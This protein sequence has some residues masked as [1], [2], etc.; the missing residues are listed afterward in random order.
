M[1]KESVPNLSPNVGAIFIIHLT[2]PYS[3]DIEK[4]WRYIMIIGMIIAIKHCIVSMGRVSGLP[5]EREL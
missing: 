5:C 2:H 4:N 3:Q 1:I